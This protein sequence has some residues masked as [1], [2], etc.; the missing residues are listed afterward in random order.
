MGECTNVLVIKPFT[1]WKWLN[2]TLLFHFCFLTGAKTTVVAEEESSK[3]P[4]IV[5]VSE[6]LGSAVF[7]HVH[8]ELFTDNIRMHDEELDAQT[9][10]LL[11]ESADARISSLTQILQLLGMNCLPRE[12]PELTPI[13]LLANKLV[14][15]FWLNPCSSKFRAIVRLIWFWVYRCGWNPKALQSIQIESRSFFQHEGST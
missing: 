10:D 8:L 14:S 7:S 3:K 4:V 13:F 6:G 12:V 2:V 9:L 11:K 5:Q 1:S 15:T